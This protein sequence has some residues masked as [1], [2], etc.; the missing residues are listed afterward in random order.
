MT[1]F[2]LKSTLSV[3]MG[4]TIG[5]CLLVMALDICVGIWC[6]I[7]GCGSRMCVLALGVGVWCWVCVLML[8]QSVEIVCWY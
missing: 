1:F 7:V 8:E 3:G 2:A 4:V 5:C 6:V